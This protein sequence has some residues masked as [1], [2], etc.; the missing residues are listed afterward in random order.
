MTTDAQV[1]EARSAAGGGLPSEAGPPPDVEAPGPRSSLAP[2]VAPVVTVVG[3]ALAALLVARA[4]RALRR[5]SRPRN[6]AKTIARHPVK[7][8]RV[9]QRGRRRIARHRAA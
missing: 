9:V 2:L 5:R 4:F 1:P 6:V 8:A 3:I 7:T